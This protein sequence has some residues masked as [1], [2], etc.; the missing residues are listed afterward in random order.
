MRQSKSCKGCGAFATEHSPTCLNN[1]FAP[2]RALAVAV[3]DDPLVIERTVNQLKYGIQPPESEDDSGPSPA[4]EMSAA[5]TY[6]PRVEGKTWNPKSA[7]VLGSGKYQASSELMETLNSYSESGSGNPDE[8]YEHIQTMSSDDPPEPA[9]Y[10]DYQTSDAPG[11]ASPTEDDSIYKS[12][13]TD[14]SLVA[15]EPENYPTVVESQETDMPDLPESEPYL[16]S[17]PAEPAKAPTVIGNTGLG[18][19]RFNAAAIRGAAI[20]G[21]AIGALSAAAGMRQLTEAASSVVDNNQPE[22]DVDDTSRYAD[23]YNPSE[24]NQGS[25]YVPNN[26]SF[27]DESER[28]ED[29]TPAQRTDGPAFQPEAN[30]TTASVAEKE[31]QSSQ[32]GFF[33]LNDNQAKEK[34]TSA[35][36]NKHSG[37][38]FDAT[39]PTVPEKIEEKAAPIEEAKPPVVEEIKK[40][41]K[42]P[43][44]NQGFF[45]AT[46]SD[47]PTPK[48]VAEEDNSHTRIIED[49]SR[50]TNDE[51]SI[52][53]KENAIKTKRKDEDE[54]EEEESVRK[55]DSKKRKK[56]KDVAKKSSSTKNKR[57]SFS[58]KRTDEDENDLED[59]EEDDEKDLATS[60]SKGKKV[61]VSKGEA[62]LDDEAELDDE[63]DQDDDEIADEKNSKSKGE[64]KD[65][66]KNDLL[67]E[68]VDLSSKQK[69]KS[70][71]PKYHD[72]FSKNRPKEPEQTVSIMGRT[73]S[74]K[75]L[76]T[77]GLLV[78]MVGFPSLVLISTVSTI[79]HDLFPGKSQST[80]S[81][82]T[83]NRNGAAPITIGQTGLSGKWDFAFENGRGGLGKGVMSLNQTGDKIQGFGADNSGQFQV[84]GTINGTTLNLT[85]AYIQQGQLVGKPIQY[86]GVL[87]TKT[88]QTGPVLQLDGVWQVTKREG[89][90]WR[91]R[92]V[93]YGGKF[94]A[95]LMQPTPSMGTGTADASGTGPS[96]QERD[97]KKAH[98]FFFNVAI[99][100]VGIGVAIAMLSLK[101]FGPSGLL[102]IWAKKEYIPSQFKAQHFKMVKEMGKPIRAGDLPLGIRE[103]WGVHQFWLPRTLCL[104]SEVRNKN[105]H[106]LIVGAGATGKSRLLASM[107]AQDI[108]NNDRAVV[109]IDSDGSLADLLLDWIASQP[110]ASTLSK[111]VIVVDPTNNVN[112]ITYNPLEFPPDGDLQNTASALVFGFKAAYTEPPGSQS[113]WNQQTA[114]IL[115][116]CAVLLMANNRT[117]TDL[118]VLLSDNDFRDVLL[119]KVEAEKNQRSEY[120]TLVDAWTNYKRLARTDQWITWIEPILN[121]VQ[122]MLSDPRLRSILTKQKSD[123]DL[124]E[125]ISQKQVLI[126]K[127]P[128]GHLDRNGNLLGSL[129]VAG[130]KQAGLSLSSRK[131]SRKQHP[132][133]LY[134]DELDSFIEKET[135]DSITTETRKLQIGFCGTAKTLQTLPEDFRNQLIINVGVIAIFAL[136]KKDADMLGP[137]MFR[138]DGRKVKHQ[139]I[140]NVFNKVN[141]SPQF[142]LIM[143]EEKLNIDRVVGQEKQTFFC[144]RVGT[145]AGVFRMK[146]PI[147]TDAQTGTVNQDILEKL[148]TNKQSELI[149]QSEADSALEED[150]ENVDDDDQ[151]EADD[152]EDEEEDEVVVAKASKKSAAPKKSASSKRKNSR[153]KDSDE[154]ESDD[155]DDETDETDDSVADEADEEEDDDADAQSSKTKRRKNKAR[156]KKNR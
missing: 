53:N 13:A 29:E 140:Q 80:A 64:K 137:Q 52:S 98:G 115:R 86:Q 127:I 55:R 122:P 5:G 20:G 133:S 100:I 151:D 41:K 92:V 60:K 107:V 155:D 37:G 17:T 143:D 110:D 104:P 32:A 111:R 68:L 156:S 91:A 146:A 50:F 141:S 49:N 36:A 119:E 93:T 71:E 7:P 3:K 99:G 40:E 34:E 136:A 48:L 152:S 31:K 153:E 101:F 79:L 149:S 112:D 95:R 145:V 33:D 78:M 9:S 73:F 18:G 88:L 57:R 44:T 128:Q 77:V 126:V 21:A 70:N 123:L 102:N 62:D 63:E 61:P 129:M 121:R 65:K 109:V 1:E 42:R 51:R 134:L 43:G 124:R 131:N 10:D 130:L 30:P 74:K 6:F 23:A 47:A 67:S 25:A 97:P 87:S 45:A 90:S 66:K 24:P 118:P 59:E 148:K 89:F 2:A 154:D 46:K 84:A 16:P 8:S 135:F 94:Q 83:G 103:E 117:L 120:I 147:F 76:I 81:S 72:R 106:I 85:K 39:P 139:T 27:A 82:S 58:N 15:A 22:Q 114:N 144:Y 38:L 150:D 56:A 132:C 75:L 28:T 54:E 105:P 96:T 11:Y 14:H 19:T 12:V 125:V 142:E 69:K 4:E 35:D 26:N 108:K 116:N 138:V 113:Q